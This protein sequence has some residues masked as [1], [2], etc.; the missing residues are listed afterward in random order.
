MWRL[1]HALHILPETQLRKTVD[2][3]QTLKAF[4]WSL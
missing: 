2:D 1:D 3:G 4:A